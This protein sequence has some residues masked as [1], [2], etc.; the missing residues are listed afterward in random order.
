MRWRWANTPG[1]SATSVLAG[2]TDQSDYI[3]RSSREVRVHIIEILFFASIAA[4]FLFRLF[5]V[6]GKSNEED[7]EAARRVRE[8]ERAEPVETEEPQPV[9]EA[10]IQGPAQPGLDAIARAEPSFSAATFLDGAKGAYEMIVE[11]F[12]SGDVDGLKGLLTEQ[13]FDRWRAA[14]EAREARGHRQISDIVR[15]VRAEI[16]QA[17]V[18]GR[19]ARIGVRFEVD[20]AS[21]VTD[22]DGKVIEGDPSRVARINEVWTFMR[23]LRSGDPN[24]FLE[25]VRSAG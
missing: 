11:A 1:L 18:Q 16:V 19:E 7:M 8:T 2:G 13:K 24:W 22:A 25:K 10:D 23:P 17:D 15:L 12:A 14:I 21:G 6:L 3:G 20:L 4:F 9:V 5:Q